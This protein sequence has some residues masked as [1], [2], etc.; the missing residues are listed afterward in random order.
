MKTHLLQK[1]IVSIFTHTDTKYR[2]QFSN[3]TYSISTAPPHGSLSWRKFFKKFRTLQQIKCFTL[4]KKLKS[5]FSILYLKIHVSNGPKCC[6]FSYSTLILKNIL[7]L[8]W[9][10]SSVRPYGPNIRNILLRTNFALKFG[11]LVKYSKKK[12][13]MQQ[14]IEKIGCTVCPRK[15]STQMWRLIS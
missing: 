3:N 13:H 14:K 6:L 9:S 8:K 7:T 15:K 10:R 4:S 12:L 2:Q 11:S 5:K 1:Q